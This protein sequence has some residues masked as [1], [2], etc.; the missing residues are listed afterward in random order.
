MEEVRDELRLDWPYAALLTEAAA[1]DAPRDERGAYVRQRVVECDPTRDSEG[2]SCYIGREKRSGH[3]NQCSYDQSGEQPSAASWVQLHH[4][5]RNESLIV[6]VDRGR[7]VEELE[8]LGIESRMA[9][10]LA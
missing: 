5:G 8:Q 4:H 2:R 9:L 3:D 7:L 10:G 1:C 6:R